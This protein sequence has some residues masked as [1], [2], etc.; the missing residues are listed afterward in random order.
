VISDSDIRIVLL[1][2]FCAQGIGSFIFP[3]RNS[4]KPFI[5]SI[6]R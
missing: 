2:A 1:I 4:D 5:Q 6:C 3:W